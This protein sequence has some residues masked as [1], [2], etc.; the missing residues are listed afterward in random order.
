MIE[1]DPAN[2]RS[3][4]KAVLRITTHSSI[5]FQ[6]NEGIVLPPF[7]RPIS[8]PPWPNVLLPSPRGRQRH[9]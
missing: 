3:I 4:L 6:K 8:I 9:K 1:F 5:E 7:I 2:H